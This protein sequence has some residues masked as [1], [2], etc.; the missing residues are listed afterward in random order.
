M[1]KI[2]RIPPLT[3]LFRQVLA[4]PRF[5]FF[6]S[7]KHGANEQ[8]LE[9]NARRCGSILPDSRELDKWAFAA[10]LGGLIV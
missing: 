1:G 7:R 8:K 2:I 4:E 3:C 5:P 10:V 6:S 9:R